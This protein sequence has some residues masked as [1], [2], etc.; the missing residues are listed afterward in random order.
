MGHPEKK[1]FRKTGVASVIH[2]LDRAI[3][4]RNHYPVDKY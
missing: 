1:K 3:H 2:P 4:R